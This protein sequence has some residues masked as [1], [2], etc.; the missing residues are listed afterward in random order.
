MSS[1]RRRRLSAATTAVATVL[2]L[3][4]CS[5][6]FD[7]Q[8]NQIYQPGVGANHRGEIDVL[9]TL[10]VSNANTTA[11]LSAS[12]VNNTGSSQTLSSVTVSTLN[13]EPLKV[14]AAKSPLQLP[15]DRQATAGGAS[16]AGGFVVTGG[17]IAGQYVKV[18]LMFSDAGPVTI[19]AP[20]VARTPEYDSVSGG[21][22]AS[23][24]PIA[25][26]AV[27]GSQGSGG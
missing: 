22:P 3:G 17:A 26:S 7:A 24:T 2:A 16:D 12:I 4:A 15:Q 1:S 19:K 27:K 13:D 10:F 21:E 20:V 18:T 8:T 14:R 25:G 9:N 5:R 6:G 11:T 23:P